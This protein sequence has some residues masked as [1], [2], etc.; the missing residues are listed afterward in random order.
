MGFHGVQSKARPKQECTEE[1]VFSFQGTS[2]LSVPYKVS[3]TR[4]LRFRVGSRRRIFG[5]PC[6]T[7]YG[8]FWLF[9][10]SVQPDWGENT[11][12]VSQRGIKDDSI[13]FSV[14]WYPFISW[15]PFESRLMY[16]KQRSS[17]QIRQAVFSFGIFAVLRYLLWLSPRAEGLLKYRFTKSYDFTSCIR[18]FVLQNSLGF[19]QNA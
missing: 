15:W 11:P 3:L 19:F 2:G 13:L 17:Q 7:T 16:Q 4:I 18:R 1:W 8:S 5:C 12:L 14:N 10:C 9:Q 6:R